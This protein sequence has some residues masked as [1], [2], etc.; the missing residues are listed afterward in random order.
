MTV[1]TGSRQSVPDSP[2]FVLL[3]L[4]IPDKLKKLN[5]ARIAC[6][7]PFGKRA[8]RRAGE[9]VNVCSVVITPYLFP[10]F[11]ALRRHEDGRH[12]R[13]LGLRRREDGRHGELGR[14]Q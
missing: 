11:P 6:L 4:I 8:E 12:G 9:E 10:A 7:K 3:M 5:F 13:Q 14:S 1:G 2:A